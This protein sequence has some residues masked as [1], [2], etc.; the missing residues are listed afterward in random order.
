MTKMPQ[1][2][3]VVPALAVTYLVAGPPALWVRVRQLAVAGLV[4]AAVSAAWPV[5]VSL[6]PGSSP[7][8]GGSTDGSV[9]NLIL[10]YNGF[11]RL[12]GS[13]GGMGGGGASF[14]GAAGLWRMF[15][16][17]VGGADRVAAAVGSRLAR[18]GAVGDVERAAHVAAARAVD[19]VRRLG[20]TIGGFN[21]G[22]N[23]PTLA[24]LEA[25][26]AKHELKYVLVSG[27]G[28]GPGR[29]SSDITSWVTS[30]GKAVSGVAGLYEVSA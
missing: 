20:V 3:M 29:G 23:A 21:G 22:D 16:A 17:Q 2:W 13:E 7:Y 12:T 27:N 5:A 25:M 28:G 15:N 4:M 9:W 8:I 24:Q 30:N 11:G 14:G 19:P 1:G 10:G 18:R 6:W 26:V